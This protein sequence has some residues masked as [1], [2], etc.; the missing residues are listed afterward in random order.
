MTWPTYSCGKLRDLWGI[1]RLIGPNDK[2]LLAETHANCEN[3]ENCVLLR[4]CR[5]RAPL[6]GALPSPLPPAR[7]TCKTCLGR[8]GF[9]NHIKLSYFKLTKLNQLN[10][11][12][13]LVKCIWTYINLMQFKVDVPRAALL[14]SRCRGTDARVGIRTY[15]Y[16]YYY[17]YYHYYYYY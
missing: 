2:Q 11:K 15:Y 3:C 9:V 10:L 6:H 5:L 16:Y 17:Y 8:R 14:R 4:Q 13:I 1:P 12:L 7:S